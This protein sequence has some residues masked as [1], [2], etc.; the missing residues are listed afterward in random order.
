M[1][2]PTPVVHRSPFVQKPTVIQYNRSARAWQVLNGKITSFPAGVQGK[3]QAELY[4]LEHDRPD[5]A[6]ELQALIEAVESLRYWMFDV[7]A[8][9]E[10][11]VKGALLIRD[12]KL[13][14]PIPFDQPA[15]CLNEIAEPVHF[16]QRVKGEGQL[17]PLDDNV[18]EI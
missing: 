8:I 17:G 4:T 10:R 5:V 13:L 18:W 7:E 11:A 16:Q 6:A 1:L 9:T 15:G 2:H 14:P 12:G 3:R